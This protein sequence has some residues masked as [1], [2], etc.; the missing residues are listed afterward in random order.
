MILDRHSAAD[1]YAALHPG[2]APAFHFLRTT[3]FS[4]LEDGK[5]EI[6]GQRLMVIAAHDKGRGR[7]GARLESHRKHID[8]Q[9]VLAGADL[10]GWRSLADTNEIDMPFDVDRD[11]GFYKGPPVTWL[12]VRSQSFTIFYPEDVHAPLGCEGEVHKAVVKV[13]VDW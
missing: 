1:R 9:F 12:D 5:H 10:M 6:D 11:L 2:F 8:I 13:R 7:Q 4:K 3:D